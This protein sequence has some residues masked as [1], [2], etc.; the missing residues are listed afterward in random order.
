MSIVTP[1]ETTVALSTVSRAV[2]S[3]VAAPSAN[4]IGPALQA[5]PTR[6]ASTPLTRT[7]ARVRIDGRAAHRHLGAREV[8]ALGRGRDDHVGSGSVPADAVLSRRL[9][10]GRVARQQGED[11]FAVGQGERWAGERS[12]VKRAR[13]AVDRHRLR[14]CDFAAQSDLGSRHQRVVGGKDGDKGRRRHV[15]DEARREVGG[16]ATFV[17]RRRL[18][19]VA[20]PR[21]QPASPTRRVRR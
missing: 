19:R 3:I 11:P 21:R 20:C 13:E 6:F 18:K 2:T 4:E 14:A 17:D 12:M 10:A 15:D 8:G 5:S 1:R 16:V 9:V 7:S